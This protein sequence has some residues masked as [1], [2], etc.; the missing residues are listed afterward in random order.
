MHLHVH[1]CDIWM[2][3]WLGY[4]VRASNSAGNGIYSQLYNFSTP[5]VPTP[6]GEIFTVT[7]SGGQRLSFPGDSVEGT[8]VNVASPLDV[9]AK[10]R[11][12]F[13]YSTGLRVIYEQSLDI[14]DMNPKVSMGCAWCLAHVCT[15]CMDRGQSNM[16][17]MCVH[18]YG[19][20]AIQHVSNVCP[21][22][23][24]G[25]IQLACLH[26]LLYMY[27]CIYMWPFSLN[28]SLHGV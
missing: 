26:G 18:V 28:T 20:G 8:L 11:R 15:T 13:W 16:Y 3:S 9:D 4:Q 1:V 5:N 25:A 24:T 23:W 14:E 22:V 10:N 21:R 27:M 12:V 19:P 2:L 17:R 7:P 6:F